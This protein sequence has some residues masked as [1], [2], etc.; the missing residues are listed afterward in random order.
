MRVG[1]GARVSVS[2]SVRVEREGRESVV[3][4]HG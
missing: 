2:V 4:V 1:V 3:S